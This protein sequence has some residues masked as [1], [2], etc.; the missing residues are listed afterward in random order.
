MEYKADINTAK[1]VM[2]YHI[3]VNKAKYTRC[4]VKEGKTTEYVSY[5]SNVSDEIEDFPPIDGYYW[6]PVWYYR[7]DT[8]DDLHLLTDKSVANGY[9]LYAHYYPIQHFDTK[10]ASC[11]ES[12]IKEYWYADSRSDSEPMTRGLY[13]F[14]DEA[15]TK[16]IS[17]S[18]WERTTG[19]IPATGHKLKKT[20]ALAPT[21][22]TNGHE[23]FWYCD[24]CKKYFSD[25]ACKNEITNISAWKTQKPATGHSYK[26]GICEQCGAFED[27]IG[28]KLAGYSVSLDGSIGVN[29]HMQLAETVAADE[30]AYLLVN[31]PNGSDDKLYI[32]DREPVTMNGKSYYVFC[33]KVAADEMTDTITAQIVTSNGSGKQYSYSVKDYADY[34][35]AHTEDNEEYAKAEKLVRAMLTYGTCSQLYFEYRTSEPAIPESETD[36]S[37]LEDVCEALAE[38]P[39]A[40][41]E[42]TLPEGMEYYGSSLILNSGII[43]RMYY[44]VSEP[45]TAA[46]Y[47]MEQGSTNDLYYIENEAVSIAQMGDIF[48]YQIGDAVLKSCPLTYVEY[49]VN[50]E[51][52][53]KLT[54]L[55]IAI[56]DYY[57]AGKAY[58]GK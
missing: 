7:T 22:T 19:V 21:C 30:N 56:Y 53:E 40:V 9:I 54:K 4:L 26:D 43:Y 31:Y 18:A 49:V 32:R 45:E 58:M 29:F 55:C 12:G 5:L 13:C 25:E 10:P 17:Q 50:S 38:L 57:N 6:R 35:L 34:L 48:E 33:C 14:E 52:S 46:S 24:N 3:K 39:A 28:A 15:C 1:G 8:G 11:T 23:A 2:H 47:G 36:L 20:D 27:G 41:C 42:G 37:A 16:P 51:S 44:R